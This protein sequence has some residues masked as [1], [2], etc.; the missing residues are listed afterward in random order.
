MIYRGVV[1]EEVRWGA[2][3]PVGEHSDPFLLDQVCQIL[4]LQSSFCYPSF[5]LAGSRD[6]CGSKLCINFWICEQNE[7][8]V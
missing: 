1:L 4:L 6:Q 3:S 7:M 5:P 2:F 8:V